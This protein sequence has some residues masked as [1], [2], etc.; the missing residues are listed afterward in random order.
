MAGRQ[1]RNRPVDTVRSTAAGRGGLTAI[2]RYSPSSLSLQEWTAARAPALNAIRM[3]KPKSASTALGDLSRLCTFLSLSPNWGH[4]S[5]PDL[6]GLITEVAIARHDRQLAE[7]G[8]S[9]SSRHQARGALHRVAR[10]YRGSPPRM[11]KSAGMRGVAYILH[12]D[13][14][15]DLVRRAH[16]P[17][18]GHDA[19]VLCAQIGAGLSVERVCDLQPDD[20]DPAGGTIRSRDTVQGVLADAMPFL[21]QARAELQHA[22]GPDRQSLLPDALARPSWILM[23]LQE[24]TPIAVVNHASIGATGLGLRRHELEQLLPHLRRPALDSIEAN[25]SSQWWR[26]VPA[27]LLTAVKALTSAPTVTGPEVPTP[28]SPSSPTPASPRR[29]TSRASALRAAK[30]A[31]AEAQ[32]RRDPVQL[33]TELT[34]LPGWQSLPTDLQAKISHYR[35][36]RVP[37]KDWTDV[38]PIARR[39]MALRLINRNQAQEPT[40]MH[41]VNVIG[42][43]LAP[44]LVWVRQNLEHHGL[45]EL[46][47]LCLEEATLDRYTDECLTGMPRG[48]VATRRSE[49]RGALR[50][51]RPGTQPQ[52]LQYR[53]VRPPYLAAEAAYHVRLAKNQPTA[54]RRRAIAFIV[55]AGY[56]AGLD[57]RDMSSIRARDIFTIDLPNG[58][59]AVLIRVG[60]DRPRTVV[61]R[62]EYQD[63]LL[64]A[65]ALHAQEGRSHNGLML[66]RLPGRRNVTTPAFERLVTADGG[67]VVIEVPRLRSTWL[68]SH[69][70]AVVPLGA[71]LAAAGLRSARAL[72]DLLPYTHVPDEAECLSLLR[73]RPGMLALDPEDGSVA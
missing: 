41:K 71:L 70:S 44:Y 37:R 40:P 48:T 18:G 21:D 51:A 61:V 72:T 50:C 20:I 66:G 15:A 57:G 64:Y 32:S 67:D 52:R 73:G 29:R 27:D 68:V 30:Q 55:A 33:E 36:Q 10:A 3:T 53:P 14:V 16:G 65:V 34:Q 1:A 2:D 39:L 9:D 26:T 6:Q 56:G 17:P 24:G 69:M 49:I 46:A 59:A 13:Q 28:L 54:S 42:S 12:P 22:G 45:P 43:H 8:L 31:H 38:E 11:R 58:D 4:K 60:G 7:R 62:A 35:P 5:I 23:H 47:L 19:L 25:A 63:L